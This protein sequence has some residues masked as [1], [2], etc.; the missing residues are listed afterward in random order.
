[1]LRE[2]RKERSFVVA[3]GVLAVIS[4]TRESECVE[5][6]ERDLCEELCGRD[7]SG[8]ADEMREARQ[9]SRENRVQAERV[10]R[11]REVA[12]TFHSNSSKLS[13]NL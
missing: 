3:F 4:R 13:L 12:N 7:G 10:E 11:K 8:E 5:V 9:E 1:V 2:F 6:N